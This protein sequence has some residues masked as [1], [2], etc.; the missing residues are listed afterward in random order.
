MRAW[1]Q[2]HHLIFE[3]RGLLPAAG[4]VL[5]AGLG[6]GAHRSG[7][8]AA[9]SRHGVT[10]TGGLARRPERESFNLCSGRLPGGVEGTLAHHLHLAHYADLGWTAVPHTVVLV[11]LPEGGRVAR[12]V[13]GAPWS[14]ALRV[15]AV[16]DLR[17]G[18][19]PPEP[20][21]TLLERDGWRWAVEPAEDERLL[22]AL[23]GGAV[24]AALADAPEGA[25]VTIRDGLLSVTAAGLLVDER[26]LGSLCA[27]AA[28]LATGMR[29]AAALRRGLDP[30]AVEGATKPKADA[31]FFPSVADAIAVQAQAVRGTERTA[32]IVRTAARVSGLLLVALYVAADVLLLAL[33]DVNAAT[34]AVVVAFTLLVMVP[35]TLRGARMLGRIAARQHVAARAV[36]RGR[37][38]FLAGYAARHGL[39]VEDADAVRRAFASPVPGTP[40]GVL[41]G[42]LGPGVEGR[43]V[44]WRDRTDDAARRSLLL[45][46]VPP[47]APVPAGDGT[48]HDGAGARVVVHA[49]AGED[50]WTAAE[51]D[52][53][54]A[55]LTLA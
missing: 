9:R 27:I 1:A 14:P 4:G 18:D 41:H 37:A 45:A 35:G 24:G 38:A 53:L 5:S 40:V 2:H 42:P 13:R 3:E 43:L 6:E 29:S 20:E 49:A 17:Q 47:T 44:L 31:P 22:T 52:Q 10:R 34:L 51:L 46:I 23:F 55:R 50:A 32:R 11:Q 16:L 30:A 7:F 21:R 33:F 15:G 48:V 26:E 12:D 36:P 19:A 39:R 8:L 54:R 25:A 28:A